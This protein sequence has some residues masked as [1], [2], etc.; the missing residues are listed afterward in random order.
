MRQY[1]IRRLLLLIPTI[2]LISILVFSFV[3]FL[4]GSVVSI[5]VGDAGASPQEIQTELHRLGLDQPV[6]AQYFVWFGNV[7]QGD[8]GRSLSSNRPVIKDLEQ[9][10]PVTVELVLL[11][12]VV[13]L[14][15][16]VPI[17]TISAIRQD[18]WADY[19]TRS[20][21][22]GGLAIPSFWLATVAIFAFTIAFGWIPPLRYE[23]FFDAPWENFQQFIFPA[24]ILGLYTGAI[25]MRMMRTSLLEVL[26]QDYIRTA[27]SKGLR[28]RTILVRHAMKNSLIPVVTILG[29]ELASL[30]GRAVV[31]EPI[32]ALP[33][34]GHYI[35]TVILARDYPAVQAVNL[36]LATFTV[37][38]NL[39]VD[40]SLAYFDP[41]IRYK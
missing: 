41:R 21:A 5:L 33:G 31:V 27:W 12:L 3:R 14:L 35:Y 10:I 18:S 22:I 2:I 32:F 6:Y 37:G 1:L 34:L 30:V 23:S 4:P 9:R 8:L 40:M 25:V 7:V 15:I 13:A 39:A 16:G 36:L 17:G 24:I 38:I 28:E 19:L 26:R 20:I 29:I 11:S